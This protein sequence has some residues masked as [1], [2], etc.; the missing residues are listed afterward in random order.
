MAVKGKLDFIL[1]NANWPAFIV[2]NTSR[3]RFANSA[4]ID[5]FGPV[6]ESDSTLLSSIWGGGNEMTPEQ[7]LARPERAMAEVMKAKF[8]I[9]GG[10]VVLFQTYICPTTLEDQKFYVFQLFHI[11][12]SLAQS[13]AA[14]SKAGRPIEPAPPPA[15]V[16]AGVAQKQKLD[17]AMQLIRSVVLDFNNAL[18]SILGHTSLIISQIDAK[19]VWFKSLVEVEKSAE[20]A[21]EI[22]C[23]LASFSRQEKDPRTL[24][25]G[26]LNDLLRRTVEVCKAPQPVELTW[27]LDLQGKLYTVHFDEAKMQQAFLKILDN[28]IQAAGNSVCVQIKT[29]NFEL[30]E[31]F[32]DATATLGPGHYVCI[33]I[34]DNGCGI[35]PEILPRIFE[36]FFTTKANH[37]GLGLAWVYGIVT[38]H[39]GSVVVTS[40]P[41]HHTSVRIYLPAEKRFVRDHVF[42]A[43]E[44]MGSETV[45]Y[46]DDEPLMLTMG[47]MVLTAFGY[48][49]ITAENGEKG[50]EIYMR[51]ASS[52]DLVITDLVMPNMS[53]R[54]LVERLRRLNPNVRVLCSSGYVRP[55]SKEEDGVFLRKPF[56]SQELLQKVKEALAQIDLT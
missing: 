50:L 51:S 48:K 43:H 19:H 20:K 9:K 46:V 23:D 30:G 16:D 56:T 8:N 5:I 35:A 2:D 40:Q 10:G 6:L 47:Q 11:P 49:V 26:N 4:A 41:G 33:E 53:G 32:Q 38:N 36:P 29:R 54:E 1:D 15:S 12:I 24:A 52:I 28:S 37:R 31:P 42:Q 27:N 25:A 55:N 13:M 17:C 22:A 7:F 3:V 45:L 39:G 21:S 44:L 14:Q 18:T 34:T